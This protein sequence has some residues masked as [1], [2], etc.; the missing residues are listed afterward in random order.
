MRQE[1]LTYASLSPRERDRIS[2]PSLDAGEQELGIFWNST[3]TIRG[4]QPDNLTLPNA[5]AL[6]EYV[7]L[8]SNKRSEV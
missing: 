3:T 8:S 1:F 5:D 7:T 6:R 2:L 4:E